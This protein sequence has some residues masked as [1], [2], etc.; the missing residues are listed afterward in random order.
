LVSLGLFNQGEG[1]TGCG[2]IT[3]K[4]AFRELKH[5]GLGRRDTARRSA[6]ADSHH[7]A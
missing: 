1:C 6:F 3:F 2:A 7:L 4:R 5:K